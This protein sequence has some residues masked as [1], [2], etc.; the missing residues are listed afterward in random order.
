MNTTTD[1]IEAK[2]FKPYELRI[3]CN[4]YKVHWNII[5]LNRLQKLLL[6]LLGIKIEKFKE[7][8]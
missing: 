2:F 1:Y 3:D 7:G 6:R 4:G 5:K 8:E